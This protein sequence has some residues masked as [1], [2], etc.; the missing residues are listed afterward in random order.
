MRSK[1]IQRGAQRRLSC[2]PLI[3]NKRERKNF[4]IKNANKISRILSDIICKDNLFSACFYFWA[5]AYS[6]HIW[7]AWYNGSCNG[8]YTMMTKPISTLELHYPMIQFLI[9]YNYYSIDWFIYFFYCCFYL[10]VLYHHHHIIIII[11]IIRIIN[12]IIR[13]IESLLTY[14]QFTSHYH[15]L[16]FWWNKNIKGS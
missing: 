15:R 12:N 13:E 1:G 14:D 6:Y 10:S 5:D 9:I 2:N 8:S 4:P 3:S 16:K 7:R 11:I